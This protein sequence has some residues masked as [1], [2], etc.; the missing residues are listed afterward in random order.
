MIRYL[1]E[2]V[3]APSFYTLTNYNKIYIISEYKRVF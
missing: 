2:N 3:K 1:S